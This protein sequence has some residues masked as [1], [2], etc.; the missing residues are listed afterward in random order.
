MMKTASAATD[1]AIRVTLN[2]E[3]RD[4]PAGLSLSAMLTHLGLDPRKVAVERNLE[5]APRS[6]YGDIAIADGDRLEIVQFVG[7][8]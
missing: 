4:L 1:T 5:I 2:G 8:G 7:G 3:A 6:A